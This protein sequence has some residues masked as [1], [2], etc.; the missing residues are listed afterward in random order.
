MDNNFELELKGS[1]SEATTAKQQIAKY[2]KCYGDSD[3]QDAKKHQM[4]FASKIMCVITRCE[5][6]HVDIYCDIITEIFADKL[7]P[8]ISTKYW[9]IYVN[10][11]RYFH[12]MFV[13]RVSG[14]LDYN[15]EY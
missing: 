15:L 10:C 4:I 3:H 13:E 14:Q 8:E 5:N 1:S 6:K 9:T 11:I 12:Y 2:F 7:S